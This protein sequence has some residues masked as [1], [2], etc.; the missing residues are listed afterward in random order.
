MTAERFCILVP[1][2]DHADA[3][4]RYADDLV[5]TGLPVLVVDDGSAPGAL[6]AVR[7]LAAA[8]EA[9]TL[10]ERERNGGKGAAMLTGMRAALERGFS[11]AIAVDADGQHEAGDIQRMR[12]LAAAE[13]GSIVSG[14]PVFGRDIPRKRLY[15]RMI[16]NGLA[17]VETG[18]RMLRD[19]MCGFRCYPLARVTAV[20][21][22][23]RVRHGMD[24]DTEVLV[25]AVWRGVPVRF[26][27]TRVRYPE[28]GVSHF[29]MFRDNVAMT[30]M[31]FRLLGGALVRLPVWFVRRGRRALAGGWS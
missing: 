24:F 8:H 4:A 25:R 3:L 13:P 15:G 31:H 14:L 2:Y 7:R 5:A 28:G 1:H 29:R 6:D 18:S 21:D 22:G 20:C 10:V 19:V 17:R 30:L 16:T 11:H 12:A 26:M 23:Y 27:E 9:V